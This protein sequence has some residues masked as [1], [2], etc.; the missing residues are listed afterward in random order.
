MLLIIVKNVNDDTIR[1]EVFNPFRDD[2]LLG[3][4]QKAP[5]YNWQCCKSSDGFLYPKKTAVEGHLLFT[6]HGDWFWNI[7]DD[8]VVGMINN[9]PSKKKLPL[10]PWDLGTRV[11]SPTC[12]RCVR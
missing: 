10:R 3:K 11:D 12:N 7:R 4:P 2:I 8:K 1:Y 5:D 6:P 9:I